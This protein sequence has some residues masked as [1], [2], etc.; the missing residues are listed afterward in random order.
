MDYNKILLLINN[1]SSCYKTKTDNNTVQQNINQV[2]KYSNYNQEFSAARQCSGG[3]CKMAAAANDVAEVS[4]T[5]TV[6][7]SD[8]EVE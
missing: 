8:G 1:Y 7:P 2:S 3:E 6:L 5:T 4:D